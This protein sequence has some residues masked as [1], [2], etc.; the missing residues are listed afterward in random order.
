MQLAVTDC[1]F[2]KS[3]MRKS[4]QQTNLTTVFLSKDMTK[5][6]AHLFLIWI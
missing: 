5:I 6:Q 3:A 4:G 2:S 1:T